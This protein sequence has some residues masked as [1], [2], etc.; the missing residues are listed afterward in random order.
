MAV[1]ELIEW[2]LDFERDLAAQATPPE[3][4]HSCFLTDMNLSRS[5]S[6]CEIDFIQT[7]SPVLRPGFFISLLEIRSGGFIR[8]SSVVAID[9]DLAIDVAFTVGFGFG[10]HLGFGAAT[11]AL[12]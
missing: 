2:S 6:R 10:F 1:Q 11:R 5:P 9:I 3:C 12:G 7:K 8:N 4:C